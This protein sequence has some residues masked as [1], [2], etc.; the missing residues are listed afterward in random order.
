MKKQIEFQAKFDTSD[1]DK[2]VEQLQRKLKDI[3]APSNITNN[4]IQTAQRLQSMGLGG[5]MSTPTQDQYKK[6]TQQSRRELDALI[7]EQVKAQEKLGK[8]IVKRDE[9]LKNLQQRQKTMI[10]YSKEELEIRQRIGRAEENNYRMRE[11]YRQR[12]QAINQMLDAKQSIGPQ[13]IGRLMQA[14]KGGG[15]G[16]MMRAGGRMAAQNPMG[17]LGVAGTALTGI[18]TAINAG[19]GMYDYFARTPFRTLLNTGQAMQGTAGNTINAMQSVSGQSWMQ[20]RLRAAQMAH[21]QDVISRRYDLARLAGGTALLG[22]GVIGGL[23]TG[24]IGS[25]LAGGAG[26]YGLLGNERMRALT[27]STL[28]KGA[29][30]EVNHSMLGQI[31]GGGFGLGNWL[32]GVGDQQ[33][34]AYNASLAKEFAHNFQSALEAQQQINPLKKLASQYY[35]ENMQKNLQAQRAMGIGNQ[36]FYGAGG[37]LRQGIQAGF[38]PEYM[39]QMSQSILGA[40]GSSRAAFGNSVLGNRMARNMNLTNAGNIL[41]TI[42]GGM[43]GAEA[44]KQATIKI[45]A[46]GTKLGLDDSKFAEENRRF[47]QAAAEVV[48]RSGTTAAGAGRVAAGFARFVGE[49]TNLGISAAKTAYQQYQNITSTT[50]GPRGVMKAAAFLADKDLSKISTITKQALM[51]V[52]ESDLNENNPIVLA[53]AKEAG[54]D[55]A[56]LVHKVS[57]ANEGMVSRF[58]E[59]DQIRDRI[60]NSM[61]ERH[62]QKLTTENI[63][64]LPKNIRQDLYKLSAFQTT[65][66]GYQGQRETMARVLGIVNQGTPA[67]AEAEG[68]VTGKL[69]APTGRIEDQTIRNLAESSKLALDSFG[70]FGKELVPT[71]QTIRDFNTQVKQ[72][73]DILSKMSPEDQTTFNNV[74]SKMLGIHGSETQKQA[75]KPHK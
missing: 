54:I 55:P 69:A 48:A 71:V 66:L 5:M 63:S 64:K 1:F 23:A 26:I 58:S 27:S 16:G 36:Q 57:K 13:G 74:F 50:T 47:T 19:A 45:L 4:Q 75:G 68:K 10:K 42:S 2:S 60:R 29:G 32:K 53:A 49:R 33:M 46:E 28:L 65:E 7:S 67:G 6:A 30:Q 17:A 18:G 56:E 14:Y 25:V 31:T 51:Q 61:K 70:K 8:L 41:G 20:E 12:D 38:T 62:I 35:S 44:T 43:G 3:Y 37:F 52:P 22:G 59:A 21:Q 72:S 9:A 11:Q 39:M 73:I 40:G 15:I 24:G 34:K